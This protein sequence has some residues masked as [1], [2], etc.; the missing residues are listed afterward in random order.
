M[1]FFASEYVPNAILPEPEVLSFKESLPNAVLPVPV[2]KASR[3][4]VPA[5]VFPSASELIP[6]DELLEIYVSS[7]VPLTV[8]ASASRVPSI[9]ASPATEKL[10]K[11]ETVPAV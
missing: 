11:I 5:Y 1:I 2:V 10:F 6:E 3:L 7:A 9:S 8:M 4:P